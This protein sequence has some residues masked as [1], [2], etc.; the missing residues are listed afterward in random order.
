MTVQELLPALR[1]TS[2]GAV[3]LTLHVQ[4]G[5]RRSELV[6]M[7]GVQAVKIAVAA[8]PVDGKANAALRKILAEWLEIPQ[9]KIEL[10]SGQSGR[11][12]QFVITGLSLAATAD[13]LADF[14]K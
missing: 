4:P 5:A 10:K 12:K 11:D 13:K 9:S 6:G 14:S 8:P 1:E 3:M 2:D 7:Y